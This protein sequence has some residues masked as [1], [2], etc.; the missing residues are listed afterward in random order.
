MAALRKIKF[1]S[2]R[3]LLAGN[4]RFTTTGCS[5]SE[6]P[7]IAVSPELFHQYLRVAARQ[8]IQNRPWFS[9]EI[10]VEE[11][12]YLV[13]SNLKA[14]APIQP[15]D[16]VHRTHRSLQQLTLQEDLIAEAEVVGPDKRYLQT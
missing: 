6:H 2:D 8:A 14:T 4:Y 11:T 1:D 16:G 15:P 13:R 3:P 7:R 5:G 10:H 12:V 9:L